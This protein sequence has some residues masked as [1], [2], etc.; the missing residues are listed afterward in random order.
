MQRFLILK[1]LFL[2]S[3]VSSYP[4]AFAQTDFTGTK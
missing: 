3:L 4:Y 2:L 1:P